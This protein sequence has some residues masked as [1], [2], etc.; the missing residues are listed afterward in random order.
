MIRIL[1]EAGLLQKGRLTKPL[2]Y[3]DDFWKQFIQ[4]D[5]AWFLEACLLSPKEIEAL[6]WPYKNYTKDFQIRTS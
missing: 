2:I 5:A 1:T 3:N 4:W 6:K